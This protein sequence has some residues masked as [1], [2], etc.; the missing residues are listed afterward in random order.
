MACHSRCKH[1]SH[2]SPRFLRCDLSWRSCISRT[3]RGQG[4][5]HCHATSP[6]MSYSHAAPALR[7]REIQWPALVHVSQLRPNDFTMPSSPSLERP[8]KLV[9]RFCPSS[10]PLGSGGPIEG[11]ASLLV[12]S[13]CHFTS[14]LPNCAETGAQRRS[15]AS[16]VQAAIVARS[17]ECASGALRPAGFLRG[18]L[19]ADNTRASSGRQ[20]A[21]ITPES[22]GTHSAVLLPV[23]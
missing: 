22:F 5:C 16:R 1:L 23:S 21:I 4:G 18:G 7:T 17:C 12:S 11:T 10:T 15:A 6:A 20:L 9:A 19:P 2:L 3:A 8:C 14:R 13:I